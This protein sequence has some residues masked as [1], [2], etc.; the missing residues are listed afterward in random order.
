[1]K[2]GYIV[3]NQTNYGDG[4]EFFG[5]Y[6][7]EEKAIKQLRKVVRNR[8]GKCPRKYEDIMYFVADVADDGDSFG[9][10]YFCENDGQDLKMRR[11]YL[12]VK[13]DKRVKLNADDKILIRRMYD[14]GKSI[15]A[16]ARFFS[17]NSR[18]IQFILFPER[19]ER[20]KQLRRE[21]LLN[22]PQRYYDKETH[23][24]QIKDIRERKRNE[25]IEL[26]KKNC[27][28]CEKEFIAR[29]SNQIYCCKQCMWKAGNRRR[30]S[31]KNPH[32]KID[33]PPEE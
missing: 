15:K 31:D 24:R 3:W 16:I 1:M 22:D 7:S 13:K 4:Y 29:V 28:I 26:W 20:N 33:R 19:L 5:V 27:P 17:V 2:E 9:I 23:S 8:F 32:L 12:R 14:S 25:N 30:F 18:T 10:D 11:D 21:R 6:R